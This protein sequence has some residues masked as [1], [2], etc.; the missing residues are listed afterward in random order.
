[1]KLTGWLLC[2]TL[3][4]FGLTQHAHAGTVTFDDL[5]STCDNTSGNVPDGY[6]GFNWGGVWTCYTFVQDPFNPN[7]SPGRVYDDVSEGQFSFITPGEFDGAWFSGPGSTT[8]QFA[9]YTNLSD[10][11]PV[12]LSGIL[13]TSGTPAFLASGYLG[14]IT[15][16]GVIT[17]AP[18]EFIMDDVTYNGGSSAVPEPSTIPVLL[19]MGLAAVVARARSKRQRL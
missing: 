14:A 13:T 8:V 11:V 12:A 10:V 17:N 2:A 6:G 4:C 18:D 5:G 15:K 9:L 19:G 3:M 16:I 7:S 1:M